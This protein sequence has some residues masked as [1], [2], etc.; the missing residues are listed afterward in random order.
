MSVTQEV[1]HTL[2][3]Q[4]SAWVTVLKRGPSKRERAAFAEWLKVSP[5]HV[6]EFLT[7]A[8]IERELPHVDAGEQFGEHELEEAAAESNVIPLLGLSGGEPRVKRWWMVAVA[9]GVLLAVGLFYF[10]MQLIGHHSYATETGEQ[11]T[12]GLEDGSIVHLNTHS[13]LK[14]RMTAQGRDIELISGEAL[15]R[16]HRDPAR[17]FRVHVGETVIEAI[18]TEFNV[19][20]KTNDINVSV[21]EGAVRIGQERLEAGEEARVTAAGALRKHKGQDSDRAIAW[22]QRRLVFDNDSLSEMVAEFNRYNTAP[23]FRLEGVDVSRYHF[24]GVFDADDPESL[25]QL[26]ATEPG[27]TVDRSEDRI[28][29]RSR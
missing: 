7:M 18:G 26:L 28:V 21:L 1:E 20:R 4:A 19:Y 9:A 25:V 15:F 8:A 22:R 24:T 14:V 27:L 3:Q 29:I 5:R 13:Q 23:H 17:P 10:P 2:T 6:R 16:V 11:R 12:L